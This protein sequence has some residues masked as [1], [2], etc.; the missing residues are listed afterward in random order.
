MIN[1]SFS[2]P[3]GREKSM[4]RTMMGLGA[5]HDAA[6]ARYGDIVDTM[7]RQGFG[8][9]DAI[10]HIRFARTLEPTNYNRARYLEC[11]I[12][13]RW[14]RRHNPHAYYAIRDALVSTSTI[15]PRSW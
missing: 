8:L 1:R 10:Q 7:K 13:L 4:A 12:M 15:M 3:H 5:R 11:L 2:N 6:R 14:L 9:R